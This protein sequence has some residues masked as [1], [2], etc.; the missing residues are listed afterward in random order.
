LGIGTLHTLHQL[1]QLPLA[2][3][4]WV[5]QLGI[6]GAYDA[7]MPLGTVV[8]VATEL[9]GDM[10]AE[11]NDGSFIPFTDSYPPLYNPHTA[12]ISLAAVVSRTVHTCSGAANT[13][14]QRQAFMSA[15]IENMEGYAFFQYMQT[16]SVPYIQI[17]SI[18]NHV[19]PRNKDHWQIE[20]ALTQLAQTTSTI[21]NQLKCP[22]L[23]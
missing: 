7:N 12:A 1:P 2:N 13:I 16:L 11:D 18:S 3:Y 15:D 8:Q 14:R 22:T 17:R 4:N 10:G 19:E 23:P 5:V 21:L 9:L 6:A 20:T